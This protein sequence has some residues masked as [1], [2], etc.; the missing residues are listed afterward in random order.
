MAGENSGRVKLGIFVVVGTTLLLLGLYLLGSKQDLF[1]HTMR[2]RA[3]FHDVNGLRTGNNVR[4]AGIDV[5]TV[6]SIDI[7]N[8]STVV[9]EMLVRTDVAAHIHANALV[10]IGSDG[11]MGNKLVSIEPGEGAAGPIVN[12]SVLQSGKA[13]DTESM[14]RTLGRSNDNLAVIT[15]DL[16]D[17]TGRISSDKSLL[18]L[19]SDSMLVN[20]V[21]ATLN[22]LHATVSNARDITEKVDGVVKDV[23]DGKG[24]LGLLIND[25]AT[26]G[27]VRQLLGNLKGVSDSL[28]LITGRI[29]TFAA[30]LNDPRGLGHALTQ[31]TALANNVRHMITHLDSSSATLNEDLKALQSNWF[32]RKYFKQKAKE[33]KKKP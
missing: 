15:S 31:D 6:K 8:D 2:V 7:V 20:N 10:R 33:A 23:R 32:F 30:D 18:A 5:G 16:R 17:L 19:L 3:S 29:G 12:G 28:N 13:P 9:V 4:Y 1:S 22:D 11:L 25:P 27:Q 24:A 26:E 21:H 14:M